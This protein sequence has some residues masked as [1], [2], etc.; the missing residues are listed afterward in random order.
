MYFFLSH[1]SFLDLCYSSVTVPKILENLLSQRKSIS[2]EGC[3]AQVLFVLATGGTEGLLLSVM[4]YDR[5]AAICHPL[6][7][8]QIMSKQLCGGPV[9]ASWG[10]GSLDALT[11]RL[12]DLNLDFCK[13]QI[14]HHNFCEL[15][16][17]F[18]LSCSDTSTNVATLLCS[19][20]FHAIWT[21]LLI[22]YSYA[23][24]VSTILSISS[25]SGRSKT[26]STC[27][28]H[29]NAVSLFHGSAVVRYLMPNSGSS[30]EL[31]LSIQHSVITPLLNPLIY[32]LKNKEVKA[33]LRRTVLRYLQLCTIVRNLG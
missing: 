21:C 2:A 28:S 32:N 11:N 6:M 18:P 14:I 33:A 5:Y 25:T 23:H 27:S 20:I 13:I 26:F 31:I 3:L 22:F 1:L 15:P 7:Y 19:V 29:L 16:S 8:R 17:L 10:L 9:W 4:A 12:L 30:L 24:I